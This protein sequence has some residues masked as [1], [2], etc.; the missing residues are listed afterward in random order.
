MVASPDFSDI[1]TSGAY[2]GEDNA[3]SMKIKY[4]ITNRNEKNDFIRPRAL[5]ISIIGRRD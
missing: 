5:L 3:E 4:R 2:A 1:A